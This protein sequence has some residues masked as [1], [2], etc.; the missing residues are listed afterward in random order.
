MRHLLKSD[1]PAFAE[2]EASLRA[3][4]NSFRKAGV[5]LVFEAGL[6]P[7]NGGKIIFIRNDGR[8]VKSLMIEGD[9]P[10]Q[11]VKDIAAAVRL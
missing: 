5:P 6:L 10:A 9:S 8:I 7:E 2:Y 3:L 4:E 1:R 11:A